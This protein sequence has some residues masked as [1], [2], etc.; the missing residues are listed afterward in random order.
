MFDIY[1]FREEYQ[2]RKPDPHWKKSLICTMQQCIAYRVKHIIHI[3][4]TN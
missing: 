1:I 2:N 4:S 3:A